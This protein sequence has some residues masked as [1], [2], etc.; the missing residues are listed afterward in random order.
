M[1]SINIA[2][3]KEAYDFL[4]ELKTED[5]SFSDV[6]LSF[7]SNKHEIMQFAGIHKNRDRKQKEARMKELRDAFNERLK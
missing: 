7:R 3:K 2:I 1:A 5:K 4:Q 6:I